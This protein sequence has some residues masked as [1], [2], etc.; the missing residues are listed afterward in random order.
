VKENVLDD[1][2]DEKD[3]SNLTEEEAA[4]REQEGSEN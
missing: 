2:R 3:A 1:S 4:G